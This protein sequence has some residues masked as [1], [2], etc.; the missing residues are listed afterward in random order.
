MSKKVLVLSTSPRREGNSDLL[1]D[2]FILGARESG[3]Q[4][5]KIFLKDFKINYCLGCG[6]CSEGGESCPQKDDMAMILDKMINTDVIV[7]ATPI[8]F[9]TMAA[10]LKTLI[11][12]TCARYKEISNKE[13][14][15]IMAA[16]DGNE[17]LMNRTVEELRGFTSCLNNPV[18]KGIVY[19]VGAWL[20]GEIKETKAIKQ[21]YEMGKSI[22]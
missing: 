21:A 2:E 12:R 4:V 7:M 1:C 11:D 6:A 22:L 8:Y 20:K 16:A 18:E 3:N 9:Y 19:G 17:S 13:F 5:E 14:Y 15:F 10:Q